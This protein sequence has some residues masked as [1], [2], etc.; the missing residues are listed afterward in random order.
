MHFTAS[1]S[2]K[3]SCALL[4]PFRASRSAHAPR[5][6]PVCVSDAF[7]RVLNLLL[8]D[9][10]RGPSHQAPRRHCRVATLQRPSTR[11][12]RV[13]GTGS[14]P[15]HACAQMILDKKLEGILDQGTGCLIV[16][17]ETKQDET[18]AAALDTVQSMGLV[19]DSLYKRAKKLT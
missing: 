16:F 9:C 1:L 15:M 8:T 4:S 6:I 14:S 2:S 10:T 12:H 19:V 5:P 18:Y 13:V 11:E 7:V 3:I 17:A